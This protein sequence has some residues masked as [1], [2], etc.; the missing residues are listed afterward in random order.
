MTTTFKNACA[1][2]IEEISARVGGQKNGTWHDPHNKGTYTIDTQVNLLFMSHR[3]LA[4]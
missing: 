2:V 4:W 1:E 3:R